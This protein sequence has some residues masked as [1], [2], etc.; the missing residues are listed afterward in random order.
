MKKI[1]VVNSTVIYVIFLVGYLMQLS[2]LPEEYRFFKVMFLFLYALGYILGMV[3]LLSQKWTKRSILYAL[4]F[5]VIAIIVFLKNTNIGIVAR[6]SVFNLVWIILCAKE[7]C[8]EKL[9]R[10]DLITRV[11]FTIVLMILCKIGFLTNIVVLRN[12]SK[13]RYAFGFS[14]P[15]TLGS[16]VFLIGLYLMFLRRKRLNIIDL[17]FQTILIIFLYWYTDSKTSIAG[18]F[19]V[20]VFTLFTLISRKLKLT[21]K[22]KVFNI[23]KKLLIYT[24]FFVVILVFLLSFLY[25]PNNDILVTINN[26]FTTR[27]EQGSKIIAYFNPTLFGSNVMRMSWQAVL[28]GGYNTALV[29][30]DIL[31]IY[32]YSTFGIVTLLLYIYILVKNI[33]YSYKCDFCLCYCMIIMIAI[34]CMENQYMHIGSNIFLIIFQLV[35]YKGKEN[36]KMFESNIKTK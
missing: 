26:L 9:L 3:K 22:Q 32:L 25:N 36:I 18:M 11:I 34:S 5:L 4:L 29:G 2:V 15:N 28:D 21:E 17:I 30:S 10:V 14:H 16:V 13:I 6:L 24:P 23:L 31:Y 1:K 35:I 20:I 8:F 7:S 33:K 12:H 27:I 19:L